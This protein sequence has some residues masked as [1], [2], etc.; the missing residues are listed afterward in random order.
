M[1]VDGGAAEFALRPEDVEI[2]AGVE[3][4]FTVASRK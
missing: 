1:P 3:A 4:V 2:A